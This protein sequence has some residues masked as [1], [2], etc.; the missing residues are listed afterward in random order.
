MLIQF[1]MWV[2]RHAFSTLFF[3]F[4]YIESFYTTASHTVS[5]VEFKNSI[6]S[7][8]RRAR[9]IFTLLFFFFSHRL[10]LPWNEYFYRSSPVFQPRYKCEK[11]NK[12]TFLSLRIV[13][14][15]RRIGRLTITQKCEGC[16]LWRRRYGSL[17]S[18]PF[19]GNWMGSENHRA[20]AGKVKKKEKNWHEKSDAFLWG[21]G[22]EE[23][24]ETLIGDGFFFFFLVDLVEEQ[25][26]CLLAW[27]ARSKR[28]IRKWSCAR[29]RL[30]C[31]W[32]WWRK[33]TILGGSNVVA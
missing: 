3:L 31:T 16:H 6:L 20:G 22:E 13:R 17:G 1:E 24:E 15:L 9:I 29:L 33:V 5:Y 11:S 14:L 19:G 25:R 28:V 27:W 8:T 30:S 10:Q 2:R 26:G 18:V 23:E 21:V 7:F 32:I 12:R 4:F